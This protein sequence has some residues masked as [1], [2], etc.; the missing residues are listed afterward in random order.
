MEKAKE[1]CN[2]LGVELEET[3]YLDELKK[4][5]YM[6]T[7]H[8]ILAYQGGKDEDWRKIDWKHLQ[9]MVAGCLFKVR[10]GNSTTCPFCGG[11][12]KVVV[13][14]DEGNIHHS[15]AEEYEQNP[16]SGLG[17]KLWHDEN[18]TNENMCP[19]AHENNSS[20]GLGRHIYGSREDALKTW[21]ARG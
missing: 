12:I 10:R 4:G 21:N 16:R 20:N 8:G 15:D 5:R 7:H 3:F 18:M 6:I 11:E 14:D 17:Y 2:L 9:N 1:M 13:C 19:V